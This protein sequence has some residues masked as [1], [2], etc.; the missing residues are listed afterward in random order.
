MDS[1]DIKSQSVLVRVSHNSIASDGDLT[2]TIATRRSYA[3]GADTLRPHVASS[4]VLW[5]IVNAQI[6]TMVACSGTLENVGDA[7]CGACPARSKVYTRLK[8]T[9][10]MRWACIWCGVRRRKA[11]MRAVRRDREL[12]RSA[13]KGSGG[14]SC[15]TTWQTNGR[16]RKGKALHRDRSNASCT[17]ISGT[18]ASTTAAVSRWNALH[19]VGRDVGYGTTLS[20]TTTCDETVDGSSRTRIAAVFETSSGEHPAAH[21]TF[22]ASSDA[23]MP[24]GMSVRIDAQ[25]KMPKIRF[26][27]IQRFA[28][29]GA[30][31]IVDSTHILL[32]PIHNA[33]QTCHPT[34]CEGFYLSW[35]WLAPVVLPRARSEEERTKLTAGELHDMVD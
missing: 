20:D 28:S 26:K 11:A 34:R 12:D 5:S 1:R 15:R 16:R 14:E 35:R 4:R 24:S 18:S 13:P 19:L 7:P 29:R 33:L 10:W 25:E 31:S 32:P 17:C 22:Y 8:R 2:H 21:A 6:A 23:W 30:N 9:L 27:I 3:N